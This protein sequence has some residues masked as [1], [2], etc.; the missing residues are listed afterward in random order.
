MAIY[1][2]VSNCTVDDAVG[3]ANSNM[4][5]FYGEPWWNMN[6]DKPLDAIIESATARMPTNLLKDRDVRRHQKVIDTATGQVVGY[7]R[8]I[9]PASH[10]DSWLDAQVPDVSEQDKA[11]F[12]TAYEA[13]DWAIRP[14]VEDSDDLVTEQF[15][16]HA[17]KGPYIR[18][19]ELD[20][21]GVH[22]DHHRRGIGSMLVKS[23][24]EQGDQLGL[25]LYMMAMGQ[26]AVDMYT[27]L[28]F[29]ELD[30]L[31]QD[32]AQWGRQGSYDTWILVKHPEIK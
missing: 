32:M 28:G 29:E 21:L 25:D 14:E 3:L 15:H 19:I 31:K 2:L 26:K 11:R 27:K 18:R 9:L 22:P 1:K 17:P 16:K 24:V 7:A 8:W 4:T 30:S 5:A 13:A 12:Q 10:A 6:W 20:Y 23:G